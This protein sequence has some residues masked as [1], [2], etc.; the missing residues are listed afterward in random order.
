MLS[1]A[2]SLSPC[3]TCTSTAGWLSAAVEK[4]SERLDGIVVFLSIIVVI[5]PPNVSIPK[6]RGVTS[7]R[8][9]SV[10]PSSPTIIPACSAAPNATASSGLIP[11]N[12]DLPTSD[13]I[14]S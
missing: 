3:N 9:T 13:S 11:L 7:R 6:V 4:V 8:R 2:N 14:A 1:F 5:I 10:T 12:G